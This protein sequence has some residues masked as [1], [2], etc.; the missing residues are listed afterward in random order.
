MLRD[1]LRR[2]DCSTPRGRAH[3]DPIEHNRE[4]QFERKIKSARAKLLQARTRID[5]AIAIA[6]LDSCENP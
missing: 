5:E 6:E 4:R 2:R 1:E 3:P